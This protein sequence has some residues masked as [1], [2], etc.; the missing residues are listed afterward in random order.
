MI[1]SLGEFGLLFA[2]PLW[3]QNVLGLSPISSGLVLLWL[4]AGA[5]MASGIGGALSGKLPPARAVQI[6]VGLELIGVAGIGLVAS[7]DAGWGV[8]APLLFIYGIGIGQ[9]TAEQLAA[10]GYSGQTA[11]TG[12]RQ[13][14]AQGAVFDESITENVDLTAEGAGVDAAFGL[15]QDSADTIN[16]RIQGRVGALSGGGGLAIDQ[17]GIGGVSDQ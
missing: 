11:S 14:Q 8:I 16:R 13:I 2:I 9:A 4:A 5:F 7:V 3:L 15:N 1:I 17:Q 10:M 6:G 12:F